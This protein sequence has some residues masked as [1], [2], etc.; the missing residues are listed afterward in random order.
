MIIYIFIREKKKNDK[1]NKD[2]KNEWALV[3][4]SRRSSL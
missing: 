3:S 1:I 4:N 2:P